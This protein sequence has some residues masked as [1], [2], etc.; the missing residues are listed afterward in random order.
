[1]AH[2]LIMTGLLF[3]I[4][5]LIPTIS[6]YRGDFWFS[7]H[8]KQIENRRNRLNRR[9]RQGSTK[10]NR[11]FSITLRCL[12]DQKSPHSS[13]PPETS[14]ICST[15]TPSHGSTD[16]TDTAAKFQIDIDDLNEGLV[17]VTIH[18]SKKFKGIYFVKN[19]VNHI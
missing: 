13:G 3:Y 7:K 5:I 11:L 10:F 17:T 14:E 8:L 4:M 2:W 1:M 12:K 19:T 15:L 6:S 18:S 9:S 16:F